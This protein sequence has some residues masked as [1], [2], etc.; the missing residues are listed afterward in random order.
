MISIGRC[1][2]FW[3]T[4]VDGCEL[5]GVGVGGCDCS[6]HLCGWVFLFKVR[7]WVAVG[8]ND[9]LKHNYG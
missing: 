2:P 6:K 8:V 1:V 5:V 7:L 4:C 3:N 9:S